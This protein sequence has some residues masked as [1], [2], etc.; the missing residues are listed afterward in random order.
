MTEDG[1]ETYLPN[2]DWILCDTYPS[3]N[4]RMQNPYLYHMPSN[5]QDF[6]WP[7]S[8]AA[9]VPWCLA[10]RYPSASEPRRANGSYRLSR[11]RTG[12]Q[13]T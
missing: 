7:V 11:A 4:E 12:R 5:R 2:H 1:H 10:V 6:A 3:G 13:C 9:R 8:L